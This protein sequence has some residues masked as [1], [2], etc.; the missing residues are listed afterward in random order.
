VL[1]SQALQGEEVV[2]ARNNRPL[3][4]LVPVEAPKQRE[5]GR[6]KGQVLFVADDFD[7][8]LEDFDG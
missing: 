1:V 4:K 5:P 8:P 6:G 2:I 3:V 7:A